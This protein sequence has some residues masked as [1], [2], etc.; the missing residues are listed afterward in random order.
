MIVMLCL[1]NRTYHHPHPVPD[2]HTQP[3]PD[4]DTHE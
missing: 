1:A 2:R 4:P 3:T